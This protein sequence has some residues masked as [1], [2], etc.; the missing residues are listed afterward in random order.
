MNIGLKF[1][2]TFSN[3]SGNCSDNPNCIDVKFIP[4]FNIGITSNYSFTKRISLQ[5]ELYYVLKGFSGKPQIDHLHIANNIAAPI[6][7]SYQ[8]F[9]RLYLN[10]GPEFNYTFNHSLIISSGL[11][12]VSELFGKDIEIGLSIGTSFKISEEWT[13]DARFTEDLEML[14]NNN[15]GFSF[16]FKAF[17]FSCHYFFGK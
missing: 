14:N 13:I 1:G 15:N 7:F 11:N 3:L 8:L 12:N 6:L 17:Y 4:G 9:P 2:A 10:V 16:R 5:G